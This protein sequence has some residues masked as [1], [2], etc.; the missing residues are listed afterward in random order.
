MTPQIS[1]ETE[2]NALNSFILP[3]LP[4]LILPPLP[5]ISNESLQSILFDHMPSCKMTTKLWAKKGNASVIVLGDSKISFDDLVY[6]GATL[7]G[8]VVVVFLQDEYPA[9]SEGIASIIKKHLRCSQTISQISVGYNLYTE[10]KF[11]HDPSL[12][13]DMKCL[14]M[15]QASIFK[16]YIGAL[17]QSIV[18]TNLSSQPLLLHSP[19]S[20]RS[21]NNPSY[22]SA[23]DS[24]STNRGEAFEYVY[25]FLKPLLFQLTKF[26][27]DQLKF[28]A[29]RIQAIYP[30]YFPRVYPISPEWALE[31]LKSNLGKF[32]LHTSG[33]IVGSKAKYESTKIEGN[34]A[35]I[36]WKVICEAKDLDGKIWSAEAIRFNKRLAAN[37]AARK[38]C[39]AIGIIKEGEQV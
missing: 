39:V 8:T 20:V 33:K 22:I 14:Q 31:D 15:T 6:I 37:V 2:L 29:L 12:E 23:T 9:F 1:P 26:T 30:K 5:P 13:F 24:P 11:D 27:I 25:E 32:N 28:E 35:I 36:P 19:V 18:Q 7:L 16:G 3:A 21:S 34:W 4:D 38:V 17:Y 10:F